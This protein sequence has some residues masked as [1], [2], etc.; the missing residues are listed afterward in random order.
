M[1]ESLEETAGHWSQAN[2]NS[3]PVCA[4]E[5]LC[6]LGWNPCLSG[7]HFLLQYIGECMGIHIKEDN[8]GKH[9]VV[10]GT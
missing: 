3:K 1:N 7:L 9:F 5:L 4:S 2:L 10:S 6:D 8:T